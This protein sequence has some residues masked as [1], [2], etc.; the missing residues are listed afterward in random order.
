MTEQQLTNQI[1]K[2]AKQQA[3]AL[4]AAAESQARTQLADATQQA[5]VRKEQALTD[6]K[7]RQ[8]QQQAEQSRANAVTLI[9][10]RA[11][12]QQ[13]V[14]AT[15]FARAREQIINAPAE[16]TQKM[17]NGWIKQ[18]AHDGD[19]IKVARQWAALFP[20]YPTTDAIVYGIIISNPIYR[21]ELT[22]DE[23]LHE[24]REHLA[25]PLAQQLGVL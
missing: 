2:N 15:A 9:K 8:A 6:A 4:V 12:A 1:I 14:L 13:Q 3:A 7:A 24:L 22:V 19:S 11:D 16:R 23:L 21:I 5:S 25:L 18:Y 20:N 10:R 17:V